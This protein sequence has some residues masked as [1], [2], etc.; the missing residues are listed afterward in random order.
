MDE[1]ERDDLTRDEAAEVDSGA[2]DTEEVHRSGEFEELRGLLEDVRGAIGEV[3]DMVSSL[4][5]GMGMFVENGATVKEGE[6]A[7]VVPDAVEL[8]TD[9]NIEE[10]VYNLDDLDLDM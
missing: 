4:K 1:E 10:L 8:D 5:D 9:G 7:D 3:R 6:G 2:M